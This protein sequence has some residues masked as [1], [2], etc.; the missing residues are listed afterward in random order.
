MS[1]FK[2]RLGALALSVA[3]ILGSAPASSQQLMLAN[4]AP[5][6]IDNPQH[7]GFLL[8][9]VK[10][11]EAV[12]GVKLPVTFMGWKEVQTTAMAGQNIL[13]F[14][15]SRTAEREPNYL[16]VQKL[17]DID[18]VFASKPGTAAINSYEAGRTLPS[19]AVVSGSTGHAEL[20]KR[21]FENLK[22][23][24][25]AVAM[26]AA[27]ARGE[28]AAAYSAG[29]EMRYAWRLAAYTGDIVIGQTLAERALYIAASKTSPEVKPEQWARAFETVKQNGMVDRAYAYY[30]GK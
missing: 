6:T 10:S 20:T 23:Y 30:F 2:L 16:W 27:L 21:K 24:P 9:I 14:P 17:W 13:F 26:T 22:L 7:S 4:N 1:I 3:A 8:D 25:N 18:E 12:M 5:Y 29:L 19:I 15:Y 28:V 11:M